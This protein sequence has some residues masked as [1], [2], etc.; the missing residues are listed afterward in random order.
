M[1][2]VIVC[3]I[4]LILTKQLNNQGNYVTSPVMLASASQLQSLLSHLGPEQNQSRWHHLSLQAVGLGISLSSTDP[5]AGGPGMSS[6]TSLTSWSN[7]T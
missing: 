7:A 1:F 4:R 3:L 2:S 5:A 6:G